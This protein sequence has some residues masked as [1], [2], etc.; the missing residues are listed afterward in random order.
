MPPRFKNFYRAHDTNM[1]IVPTQNTR[2]LLCT[3]LIS[4]YKYDWTIFNSYITVL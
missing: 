4:S 2:Y 1:F 3:E